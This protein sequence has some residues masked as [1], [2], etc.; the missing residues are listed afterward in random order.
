LQCLRE[1]NVT[2]RWLILHRKTSYLNAKTLIDK[3]LKNNKRLLELLL[4]TAQFEFVLKNMF[5]KLIE[6]KQVRWDADKASSCQKM[7]ELSEYFSGNHPLS[8]VKPDQT[9]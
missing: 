8:K 6:T 5:L 4:K 9:L 3:T 1:C 7:R 2:V